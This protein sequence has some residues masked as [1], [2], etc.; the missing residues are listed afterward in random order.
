[1]TGY[2]EVSTRCNPILEKGSPHKAAPTAARNLNV[3]FQTS[4]PILE[5]CRRAP[6]LRRQ[7]MLNPD[8]AYRI[9]RTT[10]VRTAH[11]SERLRHAV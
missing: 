5:L 2:A 10:K 6:P 7:H 9:H 3:P 8:S 11:A 1:M 4:Q